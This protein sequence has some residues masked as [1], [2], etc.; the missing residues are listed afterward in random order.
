MKNFFKARS[1]S[2]AAPDQPSQKPELKP[3][4]KRSLAPIKARPGKRQATFP[5]A[6]ANGSEIDLTS[7]QGSPG[8]HTQYLTA[9]LASVLSVTQTMLNWGSDRGQST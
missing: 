2:P 7:P 3:A 4:G 9:G 6:A 8:E 1:A 5:A